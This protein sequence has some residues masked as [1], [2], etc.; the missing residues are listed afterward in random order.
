MQRQKQGMRHCTSQTACVRV[1]VTY[2]TTSNCMPIQAYICI[3]ALLHTAVQA[4]VSPVARSQA[5]QRF[6]AVHGWVARPVLTHRCDRKHMV[7]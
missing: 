5:W 2:A 3:V 4:A 6:S 7:H 1:A